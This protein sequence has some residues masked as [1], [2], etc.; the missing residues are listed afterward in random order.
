MYIRPA[1]AADAPLLAAIEQTQPASAQWGTQGFL[2]ELKQPSACV[3][4]VA[5]ETADKEEVVGFICAR[6]AAGQ[7]EILNFAVHPS[8]CGK[9]LG[10]VL[11]QQL[12]QLLA[13]FAITEITLE[14]SEHNRVA[15][16]LYYTEGFREIGRRKNF[17]SNR[18]DA[19]LLKK[20]L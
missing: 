18:E 19:L 20:I 6:G 11:L 12:V 3:L 9:G 15:Y 16:L 10:R 13:S 5:E 1:Q 7:A 2:A 17:Y 8:Y 14:V 4:V